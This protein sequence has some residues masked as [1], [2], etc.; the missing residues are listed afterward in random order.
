[1][2]IPKSYTRVKVP[3]G[4]TGIASR[5]RKKVEGE[6]VKMGRRTLMSMMKAFGLI[7]G[8]KN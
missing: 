4:D 2:R 6:R 7:G 3:T 1:V 5:D 8:E